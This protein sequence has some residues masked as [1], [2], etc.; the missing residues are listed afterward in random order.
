MTSLP[1][2]HVVN[3]LLAEWREK[4]A[5]LSRHRL[6]QADPNA[7]EDLE[8]YLNYVEMLKAEGVTLESDMDAL[9]VGPVAELNASD[10]GPNTGSGR[11]S[12]GADTK[13][14]DNVRIWYQAGLVTA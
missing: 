13:R 1:R 8:L 9:K 7:K 4:R 14:V 11:Y 5:P 10:Q 12:S 2:L 6:Y 3:A